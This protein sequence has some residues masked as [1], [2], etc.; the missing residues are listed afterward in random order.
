MPVANLVKR[1]EADEDKCNAL[2]SPSLNGLELGCKREYF[3][4]PASL[5][6]HGKVQIAVTRFF[7]TWNF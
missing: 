6:E 5:T 3:P 1:I 7:C 4:Y 2:A